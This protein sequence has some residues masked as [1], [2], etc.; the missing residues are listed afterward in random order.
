M[1]RI[2]MA[3]VCGALFFTACGGDDSTGTGDDAAT[4][5]DASS[6]TEADGAVRT[7]TADIPPGS[8]EI[9]DPAPTPEDFED[10][11]VA[12]HTM[13]ADDQWGQYMNLRAQVKWGFHLDALAAQVQ[14]PEINIPTR[15]AAGALE[16]RL[17]DGTLSE[18]V[19]VAVEQVMVQILADDMTPALKSTAIRALGR[20][21]RGT[22]QAALLGALAEETEPT[23]RLMLVF[24]LGDNADEEG[25]TSL[26]AHF[27]EVDADACQE[28]RATT[29]AYA[30]ASLAVGDSERWDWLGQT[31][32]PVLVSCAKEVSAEDTSA[33]SYLQT[34]IQCFDQ[35]PSSTLVG[36]VLTQEPGVD[37]ARESFRILQRTP[38]PS[39]GYALNEAKDAL[40]AADLW[41]EATA[42]IATL[43]GEE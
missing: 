30:R 16:R 18:P 13:L 19:A 21:P 31:A 15:M 1:M 33:Y 40:M 43:S 11:L 32:A 8:D 10:K 3:L 2:G 29:V 14:S 34:L 20:L 39:L 42:L 9:I 36:H 4:E 22:H 7:A 37:L 26:K 25:L 12:I 24:A 35:A 17:L 38:D 6:H 5:G 27:G 28:R 23:R 41:G